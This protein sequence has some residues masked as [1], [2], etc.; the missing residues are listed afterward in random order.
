MQG[1]TG[2]PLAVRAL[3][4]IPSGIYMSSSRFW[5]P[6]V[7][8]EAV[9]H[10]V[11]SPV[12]FVQSWISTYSTNV[13]SCSHRSPYNWNTTSGF[14]SIDE[15]SIKKES[16]MNNKPGHHLG[17]ESMI[18]GAFLSYGLLED[19]DSLGAGAEVCNF[20]WR[21]GG[22]ST[23]SRRS[24]GWCTLASWEAPV[25]GCWGAPEVRTTQI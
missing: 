5:Q 18:W 19:Q 3:F 23:P 1:L 22:W 14:R 15:S 11:V 7:G 10:L 24:A 8:I 12:L 17:S 16:S 6:A 20:S 13:V 21:S 25:G 9:L 4:K 2:C